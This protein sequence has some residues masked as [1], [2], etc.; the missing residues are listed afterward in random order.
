[1]GSRSNMQVQVNGNEVPFR[2]FRED[3]F[4][5]LMRDTDD[6]VARA[7]VVVLGERCVPGDDVTCIPPEGVDEVWARVPCLV[8]GREFHGNMRLY[9]DPSLSRPVKD[10]KE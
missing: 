9:P 6:G 8:H 1:M 5:P 3:E 10:V 4:G 7:F 2:P